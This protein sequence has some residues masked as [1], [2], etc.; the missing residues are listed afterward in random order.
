MLQSGKER[1]RL[2]DKM[3]NKIIKYIF[4]TPQ[5]QNYRKPQYANELIKR[6]WERL[7]TSL[8]S[9]IPRGQQSHVCFT[10]TH[11]TE[12]LHDDSFEY[13]LITDFII[14]A[15]DMYVYNT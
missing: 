12:K 13:D 15:Y 7:V 1:I 8:I 10:M 11:T 2:C 4:H 14:T 3:A 9:L 6:T 5:C